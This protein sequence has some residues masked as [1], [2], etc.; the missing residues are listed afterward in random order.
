MSGNSIEKF[1]FNQD[2]AK[3]IPLWNNLI[4]VSGGSSEEGTGHMWMR[5]HIYSRQTFIINTRSGIMKKKQ[6]MKIKR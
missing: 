5:K 6:N 2:W 1:R 3:A 4:F